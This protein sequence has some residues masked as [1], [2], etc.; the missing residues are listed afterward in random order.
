MDNSA[1]PPLSSP[2]AV[3]L[4]RDNITNTNQTGISKL[5][6][7]FGIELILA[8]GSSRRSELLDL[9]GILYI[10]RAPNIDEKP[11]LKEQPASY[12]QRIA[13]AKAEA[14]WASSIK[15]LP[16]L[17]ADTVIEVDG[18]TISKP[19]NRQDA[20]HSLMVL[21]GREHRVLTALCL[22]TK[23]GV[24][25]SVT[26]TIVKFR[27][28]SSSE[29]EAYCST[30]EPY[31]KAGAYAIQGLAAV[32]IEYISGSYTGVMGLPLSELRALLQQANSVPNF[33]SG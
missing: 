27:D 13:H 26:Q 28:I 14:V 33:I 20:K 17:G 2:V 23:Q 21:S 10:C 19:Q 25:E 29:L 30:Q 3:Y 7:K 11:S 4:L 8:S 32:F 18:T 22:W 31:D 5:S 1:R 15:Y 6:I 9:L 24:Y 12:V 16:V